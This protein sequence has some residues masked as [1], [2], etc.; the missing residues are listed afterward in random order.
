MGRT[1][2]TA[3]RRPKAYPRGI[4]EV[5]RAGYGFVRTA[6]G[7]FFIPRSCV[8]D[9]FDGD[10]VEVAR[11]GSPRRGRAGS[12]AGDRP[13]ARVVRVLER[14]HTTLVGTY[15]VAEPDRKSGV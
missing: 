14:A 2:R 4:I 3:R 11:K 7:D 15:E 8:A 5:N 6:E 9:A 12:Q 13:E 1:R 10:L